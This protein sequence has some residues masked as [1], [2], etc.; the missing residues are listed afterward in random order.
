MAIKVM[1]AK[2]GLSSLATFANP[3][4]NSPTCAV[5]L[6]AS[7]TV[8]VGCSTSACQPADSGAVAGAGPADPPRD[9]G[10]V[11]DSAFAHDV[12]S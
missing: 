4:T 1:K 3:S 9:V 2:T 8:D 11:A 6:A 5:E 10:D 7:A 12:C